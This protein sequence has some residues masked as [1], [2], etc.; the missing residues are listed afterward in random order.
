MSFI[1][2]KSKIAIFILSIINFQIFCMENGSQG[3]FGLYS[4]SSPINEGHTKLK[5][6]CNK[7]KACMVAT[8]TLNVALIVLLIVALY[9]VYNIGESVNQRIDTIFPLVNKVGIFFESTDT[10][11][12]AALDLCAQCIPKK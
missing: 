2:K 10:D 6:K 11:C 4:E 9:K 7:Y 1:M 5:K 12:K 3:N 8:A